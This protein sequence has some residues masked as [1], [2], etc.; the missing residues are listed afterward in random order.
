M[1]AGTS[2]RSRLVLI[3]LFAAAF[4]YVEAA[5]VVYLRAL[6]YPGGFQF[7][8]RI[9]EPGLLFVELFREA[10]TLVMLGAVA[11]LSGRTHWD[12]F[13]AF[14]VAFGVWDITFYLWLRVATGWPA[15]LLEWDIL[16]LLP[17][18]WIGPVLAPSLIAAIMVAGGAWMMLLAGRGIILKVT[19]PST[20]LAAAGT[21]SLL[22]SFMRDTGAT[23]HGEMPAPY[24][25]LLLGAGAGCYVA[26][27]LMLR[28]G[29]SGAEEQGNGGGSPP[30][31]PRT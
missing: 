16:F 27:I 22:Y 2:A 28:R 4:G 25:Y 11:V 31:S 19:L 21:V 5:V 9:F 30:V 18:P 6:Y 7:P 29:Y 24:S 1:T 12:R 14:L 3:I 15:T 20:V 23:L 26:A 13:G 17:L 8:L 10:A